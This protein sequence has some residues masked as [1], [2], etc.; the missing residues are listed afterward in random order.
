MPGGSCSISL[1]WSNDGLN[2]FIPAEGQVRGRLFH[3]DNGF[4]NDVELGGACETGK[5]RFSLGGRHRMITERG[6]LRRSDEVDLEAGVERVEARRSKSE[7]SSYIGLGLVA[8]GP[9][10]GAAW[11]DGF[12]RLI[13]WGRTLSGAQLGKLQN[14]YEGGIRVAPRLRVGL[15]A[16][17]RASKRTALSAGAEV[18]VSRGVG[19]SGGKLEVDVEHRRRAA[20]GE[21]SFSGAV[22]L[23]HLRAEEERL[24]F[25]GAY[26][27]AKSFLEPWFE[28]NYRRGSRSVGFRLI[29]NVEGSGSNQ[30][31]LNLSQ[32]WGS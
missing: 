23:R 18:A 8:T 24:T 16:L 19:T 15:N 17:W 31:S 4:T 13:N 14:R 10:G 30:G 28:I 3:D 25:P 21:L 2:Y 6:G 22:A 12:H 11:Q 5:R 29:L 27:R 20:G 26:P 1:I 32:R 9:L 7:L